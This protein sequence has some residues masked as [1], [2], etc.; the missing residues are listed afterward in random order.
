MYMYTY[1]YIFA[2]TRYIYH[3]YKK[4]NFVWA[5][6][7]TGRLVKLLSIFNFIGLF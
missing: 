1:M 2:Y 5:L 7:I 4:G 3:I 6:L